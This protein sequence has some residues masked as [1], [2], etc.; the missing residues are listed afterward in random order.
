MPATW[1][2]A[3]T[4]MTLAARRPVDPRAGMPPLL[5]AQQVVD[6]IKKGLPTVI[7]DVRKP[8][9]F[10]RRHIHGA[11]SLPHHTL[12]Q[13]AGTLNQKPLFVFYCSCPHDEASTGTALELMHT[14]HRQNVAVLKGGLNEWLV[15]NRPFD[16]AGD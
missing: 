2:A 9:A 7:A 3:A 12:K 15:E 4:V 6:R 5:T 16:V 13:W 11:V 14:Y 1:L 10:H 8:N